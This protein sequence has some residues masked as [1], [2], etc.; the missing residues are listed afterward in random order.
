MAVIPARAARPVPAAVRAIAARAIAA[1]AIAARAIA[2]RAIAA[3][4][5]AARAPVAA[6]AGLL[7]AAE[8]PVLVLGSDVWLDRADT[9]ARAAAEELRLPVIAN[10]QGRGV[11]PA[12]HELLVT[13]ARSVAFGQADLVIVV[14]TPLD[15]RLGYGSF[16]GRDGAP[17]AKVVH[18][19]DA[20]AQLAA[21]CE[22]AAAAAGDLAAFCTGLAAAAGSGRPRWARLLAAAAAGRART[23]PSRPTGR[24]WPATLTRCTRCGCTAS[25]RRSSLMTPW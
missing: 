16:G 20:P 8:R 12:G 5:I 6:I 11:L 19:A 10:G 3:R 14:G 1:R 2:A 23:R 7:A 13:R 15:F 25:W 18:V 22:L 4:A 24:C 9:A 21:H 17:Q